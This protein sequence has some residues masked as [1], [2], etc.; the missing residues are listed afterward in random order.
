ME[1]PD[2]SAEHS[3][4]FSKAPPPLSLLDLNTQALRND[5]YSQF[6]WYREHDPVHR[7]EPAAPGSDIRY[8]LTRYD[9]VQACLSDKRFGRDTRAGIWNEELKETPPEHLDY[10]RTVREWA[11]FMDPPRHT[12]VRLTFNRILEDNYVR[13]LRPQIEELVRSTLRDLPATGEFDVMSRFASPL[14]LSVSHHLLGLRDFISVEN[15]SRLMSPIYSAISGRYTFERLSAASAAMR[16][17]SGFFS[18]II[19]HRRSS[20]K[21]TDDFVDRVLRFTDKDHLL[22][23]HQVIPTCLLLLSATME[24]VTNMIGNGILTLLRHPEQL[25]LLRDRPELYR[26]AVEEILRYE[27]P[28][29]QMSRH[30]L[31]PAQINGTNIEK[32]AAVSFLLGAANRDPLAFPEPDLFDINR[33]V[34]RNAAFGFGIHHCPGAAMTLIEGEIG[35]SQFFDKFPNITLAPDSVE[36]GPSVIFRGLDKLQVRQLNVAVCK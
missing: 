18:D 19:A 11:L 17:L 32:G 22:M 5:P 27:S 34:T 35:I 6:R 20:P 2:V 29:Q 7:R 4:P 30:A 12:K 9:D 3:C 31:V 36:W 14:P 23:E 24:N 28:V 13:S 16:T 15:L 25:A 8:F 1:P 10:A 21:I 26:Q 33:P